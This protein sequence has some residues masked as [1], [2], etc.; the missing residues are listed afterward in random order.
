[1]PLNIRFGIPQ[2]GNYSGATPQ[3]KTEGEKS[4]SLSAFPYSVYPSGGL[5]NIVSESEMFMVHVQDPATS[6]IRMIWKNPHGAAIS[7]TIQNGKNMYEYLGR[8]PGEIDENGIY[9]VEISTEK[10]N[11]AISFEV[12]K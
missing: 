9:T 6:W 10:E 3:F 4:L 5:S 12:M 8:F 2:P 11:Q 1:M 7:D